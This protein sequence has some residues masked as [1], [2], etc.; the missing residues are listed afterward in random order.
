MSEPMYSTP[1]RVRLELYP[2]RLVT[3]PPG[4]YKARQGPLSIYPHHLVNNTP[5]IKI[6]A[7]YKT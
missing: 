6:Y 3:L 5:S 2:N 4:E 1:T 7:V